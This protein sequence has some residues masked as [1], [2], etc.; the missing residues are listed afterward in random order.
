MKLRERCACGAE[1]EMSGGSEPVLHTRQGLWL[2]RHFEVCP[3]VFQMARGGNSAAPA[4]EP[5]GEGVL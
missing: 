1:W 4:P 5:G 3:I 2:R